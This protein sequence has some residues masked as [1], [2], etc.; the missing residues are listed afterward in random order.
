MEGSGF[1]MRQDSAANARNVGVLIKV[2]PD[3]KISHVFDLAATGSI[4]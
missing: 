2:L 3:R 4:L 1:A